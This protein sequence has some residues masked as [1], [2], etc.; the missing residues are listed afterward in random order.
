MQMKTLI[1]G[2]ATVAIATAA[3]AA[4]TFDAATGVGFVGKGDVQLAFGMN[5]SQIQK[6]VVSFSA[7]SVT[8]VETT[9][10]CV[11]DNNG[12]EQERSNT[13]KTKV[14]GV[15]ND[16]ERVRNQVTGYILQGYDGSETERVTEQGQAIGSCPANHTY[17]PASLDV[18]D[19]VTTT[20]LWAQI[21]GKGQRKLDL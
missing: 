5:N 1:A 9:W 18:G 6:A 13:S 14:K 4:V 17:D 20:T 21:E 11:N 2:V 15:V 16:L 10:D 8:E 3:F 19:E 7:S 12:R